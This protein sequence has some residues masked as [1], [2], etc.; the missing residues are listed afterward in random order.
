MF[1]ITDPRRTDM[2]RSTMEE[3][4]IYLNGGHVELFIDLWKEQPCLWHPADP[5]Y[6]LRHVRSAPI[7]A[8]HTKQATISSSLESHIVRQAMGAATLAISST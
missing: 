2:F 4:H 5:N 6:R 1:A 3:D 8:T 7:P